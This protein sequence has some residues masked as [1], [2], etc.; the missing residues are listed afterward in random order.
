[1]RYC[2]FTLL[3]LVIF[4]TS[5][6]C[7][8][9]YSTRSYRE[10]VKTLR[11]VADGD[12]WAEPIVELDSD[13]EVEVSFDLISY[14][15]KA[16]DYK[17]IH[18][19]SDWRV[20]DISSMEYVD[21]FD[22]GTIDDYEY[23]LNTTTN[24]IHYRVA[25][26]NENTRLTKS[27]NYVLLVAEDYDYDNPVASFCFSVVE[28]R[29]IMEGRVT[30]NTLL[31]INGKYQQLDLVIDHSSMNTSV[32]TNE[33]VVTV[34]QNGRKDN[35]L[36]LT[37]PTYTQVGKL[38]YK[39]RRELVFEGGNSYRDVDFASEYTYGAGIE[40][41]E[42]RNNVMHVVL[43]ASQERASRGADQSPHAYGKM[44]VNRQGT[45]YDDVEADYMWVHFWL[46]METP[47]LDGSVYV[48]GDFA[49]S[50]E[51]GE[52]MMKYDF[53]NKGYYAD[54]LLKQG[55][56]SYLY[57]FLPKGGRKMTML[58]IEGSYWQTENRYMVKVYHRGFGDRYDRLVGV[59]LIDD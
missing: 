53:D 25:F 58:P 34:E 10:D 12:V 5:S 42:A 21:G 1:M 50:E 31:E 45:D 35:V 48:V 36:T 37:Q 3:I 20:S 51:D 22:N 59:H 23:S 11:V 44:V 39:D 30:G 28:P 13:S 7:A 40:R 55:G 57:G 52:V 14:E 15:H 18:C 8:Q 6:V 47:R 9:H 54:V 38:I 41:I 27:G 56:Y 4:F 26:P 16:F 32:P 49:N 33:F 19:T 43:D 46:P 17:I 24:Y 2:K 29:V